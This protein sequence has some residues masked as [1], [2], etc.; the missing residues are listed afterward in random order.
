MT[1]IKCKKCGNEVST[2]LNSCPTCGE[3]IATK[4]N[5]LLWIFGAI[6]I[7]VAFVLLLLVV[8][9][10]VPPIQENPIVSATQEN[11][12]DRTGALSFVRTYDF[13]DASSAGN[14]FAGDLW[15]FAKLYPQASTICL[16]TTIRLGRDKYGNTVFGETKTIVL[17]AAELNELR[18]YTDKNFARQSALPAGSLNRT[19]PSE[20]V[21]L[22]D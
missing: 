17:E 13:E 5:W 10:I 14:I 22:P 21:H 7:Y 4:R 8:S 6:G 20:A 12:Q 1:L 9:A 3:A 15:S 2:S 19:C 18:K 16:S 11:S